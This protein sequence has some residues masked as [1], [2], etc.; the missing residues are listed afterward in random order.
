MLLQLLEKKQLRMLGNTVDSNWSAVSF[1]TLFQYLDPDIPEALLKRYSALKLASTTYQNPETS[2]SDVGAKEKVLKELAFQIYHRWGNLYTHFY[3]R[4]GSN[5]QEIS[6]DCLKNN[7]IIEPEFVNS[8][9]YL[10]DIIAQNA[11]LQLKIQSEQTKWLQEQ[12]KN[13][14]HNL[15]SVQL[16]LEKEQLS[17]NIRAMKAKMTWARWWQYRKLKSKAPSDISWDGH[18]F[19]ESYDQDKQ[20][21]S[22]YYKRFDTMDSNIMQAEKTERANRDRGFNKVGIKG[23][24]IINSNNVT[25]GMVQRYQ[26]RIALQE[27]IVWV[28]CA[29][30]ML[31]SFLRFSEKPASEKPALEKYFGYA[32]HEPL[33]SKPSHVWT[34][35]S[36]AAT[37]AYSK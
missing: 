6:N 18:T 23:K 9:Q 15:R 4:N 2:Y 17:Q 21:L 36:S 37:K 24:E 20:A 27:R 19:I 11:E 1:N 10:A 16:Q 29:Y 35:P 33:K 5:I 8:K 28:Q 34:R 30:Y 12:E 25:I 3:V 32:T 14:T 22:E 31:K 13:E 26:E 7:P